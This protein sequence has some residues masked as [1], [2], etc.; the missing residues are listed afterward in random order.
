M[1]AMENDGSF[2]THDDKAKSV[3]IAQ[4]S[5]LI[6]RAGLDY[7]GWR[8]VCKRVRESCDLKPAK[9]GRRLPRVLTGDEFRKFYSVVDRA[10]NV[11]H[12]LM[13]RLLFFTGVRVTS[14]TFQDGTT[15]LRVDFTF[16]LAGNVLTEIRYN[17]VA[18]HR[19]GLSSARKF[20]DTKLDHSDPAAVFF[21]TRTQVGSAESLLAEAFDE[22]APDL[23]PTGEKP[24]EMV[25]LGVPDPTATGSRRWSGPRCPPS[26]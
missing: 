14:K 9:K 25:V 7:P 1:N 2:E 6:R 16:D 18:G 23:V 12:A 21:R 11:Q 17:D 19:T 15:Q 3:V 5:R 24:Y 26:N 13:L 8:Y 4:I 20:L 22:A 10:D